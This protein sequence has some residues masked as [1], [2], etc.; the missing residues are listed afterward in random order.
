MIL[1]EDATRKT[2]GVA[3]RVQVTLHNVILRL[4]KPAG[5]N[6][7]ARARRWLDGRLD[8]AFALLLSRQSRL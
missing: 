6:N 1:R 2:K 7:V 4:I 5:F 8:Q 3:V